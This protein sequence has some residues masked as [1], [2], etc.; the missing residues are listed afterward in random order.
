MTGVVGATSAV[1]ISSLVGG[2]SVVLPFKGM[3]IDTSS[4]TFGNEAPISDTGS[5]N[6]LIILY[7]KQAGCYALGFADP[8]T[9]ANFANALL[10]LKREAAAESEPRFEAAARAY[11]TA[12]VKPPLPEAAHRYEV[13][14]EDAVRHNQLNDAADLYEQATEAAPWWPAAHYDRALILANTQDYDD[15]VLEMKR[16]LMLVPHAP[17]A[18]AARDQMYIWERKATLDA[19]TGTSSAGAPSCCSGSMAG[20][21]VP[22]TDLAG[23]RLE[24]KVVSQCS[25][26]QFSGNCNKGLLD[27][28][29]GWVASDLTSKNVFTSI[30]GSN[31]NLILTIAMTKHAL[32]TGVLG[33]FTDLVPATFK[34]AANYQLTDT[35]GHVLGSGTVTY[36]GAP[37]EGELSSRVRAQMEQKFVAKLVDALTAGVV[38]NAGQAVPQQTLSPL[39]GTQKRP[40]SSGGS[41]LRGTASAPN[42]QLMTGDGPMPK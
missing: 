15:A 39:L 40:G 18:P 1:F 35:A 20:N 33:F 34:L 9:A 16:Y 14:A 7:P 32:D 24:I 5:P 19:S 2:R 11:Q 38:A 36:S 21:P 12:A 13:Q 6:N 41:S 31:P 30:G 8:A 27:K 4:K 10:V 28:I 25:S 29:Q 17:N 37:G 3:K 22:L 42:L 26:A 23:K